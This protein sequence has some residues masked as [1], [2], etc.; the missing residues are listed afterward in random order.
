MPRSTTV[1][2]I[3]AAIVALLPIAAQAQGPAQIPGPPLPQGAGKDLV[4]GICTQCHQVNMITGSSGYTHAGWK[5]LTSTMIDLSSNPD[6]QSTMIEYLA[7][8]FPPNTKRAPKLVPGTTE[9]SFT[10]WQMPTLGQRSRDPIQ[11]ADGSIWWAGQF[12]NLIGR[13]NPAT[14]AMKE[15]PLFVSLNNGGPGTSNNLLVQYIYQTG[16]QR[17]QIGY[18]SA[19]SFVLMLILMAVAIIQLIVNRRVENR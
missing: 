9:I 10:E 13:L 1:T 3:A 7:T 6:A 5:E 18:A 12:G 16:F 19:A 15:Y 4:E 11:A 17:G 8:N 2:L 14:G